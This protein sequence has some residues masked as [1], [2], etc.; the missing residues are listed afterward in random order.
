VVGCAM[1]RQLARARA[2]S[3]VDDVASFI[4]KAPLVHDGGVAAVMKGVDGGASAAGH[5]WAL[6]HLS[7]DFGA[8]LRSLSALES[9]MEC[10]PLYDD[11]FADE[12]QRDNDVG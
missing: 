3:E 11:D 1:G 6:P 7:L 4:S 9:A 10:C 12:V 2:V 8:D 5:S